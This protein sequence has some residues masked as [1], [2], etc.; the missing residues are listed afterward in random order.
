MPDWYDLIRVK[1]GVTGIQGFS[2]SV[3][4]RLHKLYNVRGFCLGLCAHWLNPQ[5]SSP[6][7]AGV[8]VVV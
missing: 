4:K 7:S 8:A 5:G 6:G 1:P 3:A 2:Q